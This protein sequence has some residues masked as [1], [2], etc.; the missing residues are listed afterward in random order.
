MRVYWWY[1]W[2][3]WRIM[4]VQKQS[5]IMQPIPIV[6]YKQHV[7]FAIASAATTTLLFHHKCLYPSCSTNKL[8]SIAVVVRLWSNTF[9]NIY[10]KHGSCHEHSNKY[11]KHATKYTNWTSLKGVSLFCTRYWRRDC[12]GLFW[13]CFLSWG[14]RGKSE[15]KFVCVALEETEKMRVFCWCGLPPA[16]GRETH[17]AVCACCL[18]WVRRTK[19]RKED[20]EGGEKRRRW[21]E[22]WKHAWVATESAS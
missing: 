3:P 20:K 19:R 9:S 13:P 1:H 15:R 5:F 21:V 18:E 12:A 22:G 17:D 4:T 10:V 7:I 6:V 2:A 8:D 11:E 16:R 14:G